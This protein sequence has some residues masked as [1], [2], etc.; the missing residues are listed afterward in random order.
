MLLLKQINNKGV[1]KSGVFGT[2]NKDSGK[3]NS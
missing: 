2:Y 1:I 3:D